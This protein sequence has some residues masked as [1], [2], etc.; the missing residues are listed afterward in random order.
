MKIGMRC[1]A[2]YMCCAVLLGT[3][4]VSGQWTQWGGPN[5]DFKVS[6]S[7]LTEKWPEDGPPR[8]WRRELGEGYSTIVVDDG[9]L[10]TMYRASPTDETER[11]V[12]LDAGTGK[13]V[14][15][16]ESP[17]AYTE[18]MTNYGPGPHSTPLIVGSR[19]FTVGTNAVLHCFDKDTGRVLWKGDLAK[20]YGAVV[21][22]FG[23]ASSPVA[24]KN[25]IILQADRPRTNQRD[26]YYVDP[27]EDAPANTEGKEQSVMA[28]DQ[29]SGDLVWKSLDVRVDYAAPLMITFNGEAQVVF[30]MH[31]EVIGLN[32]ET[33]GMLWRVPV[34]PVPTENIS[35]PIWDGT[36]TLFVSA[37]YN[38]GSRG[39]KL[40]K[41][42]DQTVAKEV[43]YSR[44]MRIHHGNA[45]LVGN[46]VYGSSGDVAAA[47]FG[48]VDIETGKLLW[49]TRDF[50]K[51]N[52][53][54]ADGKLIILD[55]DGQLAIA[56][57]TPGGLTVHSSFK[58]VDG[59]AWTV[60]T[61]AGKTLYVRDRKHIMAL[62]LG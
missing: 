30:L 10:Y 1:V 9:V 3:A 29:A 50:K 8:L 61:L 47:L 51:A 19:L 39:I 56:T 12:A 42:G 16:H 34:E 25:L 59:R 62:D 13:T 24:Y 7:A 60:P 32:P 55:E 40:T 33:G 37:A 22:W 46:Y 38:S 2:S 53:V 23:Y 21:P 43:W 41:Q 44:K 18:R 45:V 57:A 15:E 11:V 35:T 58:L 52:C 48:C 28:F 31:A 4:E 49:R 6:T 27:T 20:E 54:C 14:W 5:R 26:G 17:S 36:D